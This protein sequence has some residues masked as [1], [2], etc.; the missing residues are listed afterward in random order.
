MSD[1]R[2]PVCDQPV[3]L[4]TSPAL[5][6]CSMRC[7]QIDLGRWLGERYSMPIERP[8]EYDESEQTTED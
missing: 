7:K 6:F 4:Q 5:P 1:L 2:C 8:Y 3:D